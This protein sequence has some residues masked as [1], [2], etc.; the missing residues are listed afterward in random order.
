MPT[1][2]QKGGEELAERQRDHKSLTQAQLDVIMRA[3]LLLGHRMPLVA[4]LN[5]ERE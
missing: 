2:S 3:K 1:W 4:S 5:V